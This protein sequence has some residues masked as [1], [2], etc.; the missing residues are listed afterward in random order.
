LSKATA[1]PVLL[2]DAGP[3]DM[4]A[5]AAIYGHHV[6]HGL[7]TFEEIPPDEGEMARRCR[8]LQDQGL[9]YLIAQYDDDDGS[10][11]GA[12]QILGFAYAGLYRPRP[13][14]RFTLEDS[15]YVDPQHLNRGVGASL[16]AQLIERSTAL[17]YRQMVAV[18]GDSANLGSIRL[19]EAFGFRQVGTLNAPGFKLGRWVDVVILQ[20]ALGAG[21]STLPA[22]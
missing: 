12:G 22:K 21:D 6:R 13:A 9:P 11:Q 3:E 1:A 8:A 14:Y 19:H 4:A 16:L 2:R 5:L 15:I 18:I 20:R 10:G 7:A 17:G